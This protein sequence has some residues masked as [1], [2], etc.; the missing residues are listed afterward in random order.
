MSALICQPDYFSM[1]I[2]MDA[3]PSRKA[4]KGG[5]LLGCNG[6]H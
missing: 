3:R 6:A 5:K 1:C 2:S 4:Q